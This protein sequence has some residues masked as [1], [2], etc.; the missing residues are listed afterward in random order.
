MDLEPVNVKKGKNDSLQAAPKQND[1]QHYYEK[2]IIQTGQDSK[3]EGVAICVTAQI[4]T[5][6]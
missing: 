6:T 3:L 2:L 5:K 4:K 1:L